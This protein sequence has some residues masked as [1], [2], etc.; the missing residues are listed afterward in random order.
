[1]FNTPKQSITPSDSGYFG[2]YGG[3]YIPEILYS[4]FEELIKVL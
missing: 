3:K 1:M 2:N 4:T